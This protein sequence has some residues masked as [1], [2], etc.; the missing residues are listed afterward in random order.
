MPVENVVAHSIPIEDV[1][2]HSMHVEKEMCMDI[3]APRSHQRVYNLKILYSFDSF[4]PL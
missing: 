3:F 4:I 2:A 1:V